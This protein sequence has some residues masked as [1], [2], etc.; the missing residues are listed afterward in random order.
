M[1]L[2]ARPKTIV[3][4]AFALASGAFPGTATPIF[5]L[6]DFLHV[7][8]NIFIFANENPSGEVSLPFG[9]QI[10][11]SN[12]ILTFQILK[13]I[14]SLIRLSGF[15]FSY[16]FQGFRIPLLSSLLTLQRYKIILIYANKIKYFL[17]KILIFL[18][19]R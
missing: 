1:H 15:H 17:L 2:L 6:L 7:S 3:S 9:C 16:S 18:T 12:L 5:F 11:I 13:E 14:A 19:K 4:N 10:S 8:K